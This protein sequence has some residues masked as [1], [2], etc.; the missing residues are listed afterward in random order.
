M[1]YWNISRT[2][3]LVMIEQE[4]RDKMDEFRHHSEVM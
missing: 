1:V 3:S 2:H 4:M